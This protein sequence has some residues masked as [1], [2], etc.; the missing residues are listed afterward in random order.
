[1]RFTIGS[2][3]FLNE[4]PIPERFTCIGDDISPALHWSGAPEA[5]QT[6]ALLVED[7]DAPD[8]AA[9]QRIFT[10]W[11]I[12]NLPFDSTGLVENVGLDTLPRGARFGQNDF[13]RTRWG[14]PCPPIGRHR[15]Y[16]KLYALDSPVPTAQVLTRSGLLDAVDGHV[17]AYAEL[18]GTFEKRR[19]LHPGSA[20]SAP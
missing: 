2:P 9:P 7:P 15:Y 19:V 16:F 4:Q 12:Y 18:M 14:G 20:R 8:P 10:H 17:L 3:A 5:T 6:L 11:V 13:E 1:M